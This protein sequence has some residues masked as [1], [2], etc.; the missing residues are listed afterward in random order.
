MDNKAK[1]HTLKPLTANKNPTSLPKAVSSV[2]TKK[3]TTLAKKTAV[4]PKAVKNAT[5]K[6][7]ASIQKPS[8]SAL[9]NPEKQLLTPNKKITKKS[10]PVAIKKIKVLRDS[11]TIPKSEFTDLTV[12]KERNLA[13][14]ISVKKS[15]LLR[16]GIK[17]LIAL[18]DADLKSAV[19]AVPIVATGRPTKKK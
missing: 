14:G 13:I 17:L 7:V 2:A 8:A 16:A 11:Y 10:K 1:N 6:V 9:V 4:K 12:L 18:S 15:E 19:L 5:V 3:A